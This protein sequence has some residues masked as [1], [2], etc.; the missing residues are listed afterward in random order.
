MIEMWLNDQ[1]C[2]L[3]YVTRWEL[4]F[5]LC[6]KRNTLSLYQ[7][8]K[9]NIKKSSPPYLLKKW[10][11]NIRWKWKDKKIVILFFGDGLPVNAALMW[12]LAG[13]ESEAEREREWMC[14]WPSRGYGKNDILTMAA[15]QA[16]VPAITRL[17]QVPGGAWNSRPPPLTFIQANHLIINHFVLIT[18]AAAATE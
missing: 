7:K 14:L 13:R 4:P 18:W 17:L 12:W 2:G 10:K 5:Y 9:N 3:F 11:P 6:Q 1:I 15:E 16:S 8:L